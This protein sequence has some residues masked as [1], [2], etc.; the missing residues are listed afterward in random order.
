MF[1]KP[2]YYIC[3][4][5]TMLSEQEAIIFHKLISSI[6]TCLNNAEKK[7]LSYTKTSTRCCKSTLQIQAVALFRVRRDTTTRKV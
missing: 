4:R 6:F 5:D 1:K 2:V 7:T 3:H